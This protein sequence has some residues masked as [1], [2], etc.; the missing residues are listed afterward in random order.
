MALRLN[1]DQKDS[2]VQKARE[3]VESRFEIGT[4]I[5]NALNALRIPRK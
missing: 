1:Q 5:T 3:T 2:L 4:A